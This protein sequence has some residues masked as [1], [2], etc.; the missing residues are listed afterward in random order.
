MLRESTYFFKSSKDQVQNVQIHEF[1][2]TAVNFF[3][4]T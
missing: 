2:D 1:E 3:V 4:R